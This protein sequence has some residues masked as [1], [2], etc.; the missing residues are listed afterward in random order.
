MSS[1]VETRTQCLAC[2][3]SIFQFVSVMGACLRKVYKLLS[4]PEPDIGKIKKF[5]TIGTGATVRADRAIKD[6]VIKNR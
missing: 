4:E 3:D 2:E 6:L 5:I 1:D